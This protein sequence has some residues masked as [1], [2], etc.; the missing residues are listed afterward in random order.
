[1][2]GA[3]GD[4]SR[5]LR[6][7]P[8]CPLC[9]GPCT[10]ELTRSEFAIPDRLPRSADGTGDPIVEPP[11]PPPRNRGRRRERKRAKHGPVEDRMRRPEDDR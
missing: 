5:A 10:H 3:L 8:E 9:D 6:G 7:V 1:M 11:K 4:I 2:A